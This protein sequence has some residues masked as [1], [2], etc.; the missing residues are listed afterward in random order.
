MGERRPAEPMPLAEELLRQ[1][2]M[3]LT[4]QRRHV[5]GVFLDH[6]GVHWSADQ[7]REYLLPHMPELARGTTYKVL[8]ELVRVGV[9]EELATWDG[10]LLYGLR[11][12]PHHH[13]FC[14][15]CRRWFD[16]QVEGTEKLQIKEDPFRS[17]ISRVDVTFHGVCQHCQSR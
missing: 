16:I 10:T 4:P 2:G 5:L 6:P 11:L 1:Y 15:V 17:T 3:R 7:A 12:T 8:N 9:L 13:F 14:E